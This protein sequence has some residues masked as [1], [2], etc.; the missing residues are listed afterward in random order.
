MGL[1]RCSLISLIL[2]TYKKKLT[3][4][5]LLTSSII[6]LNDSDQVCNDLFHYFQHFQEVSVLTQIMYGNMA[7]ICLSYFHGYNKNKIFGDYW[8]DTYIGIMF[9][10]VGTN[11]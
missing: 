2:N 3:T 7:L 10:N 11:V 6:I 5:F 1:K 9:L 4:C 8:G